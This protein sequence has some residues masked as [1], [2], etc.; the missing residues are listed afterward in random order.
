MGSSHFL[1]DGQHPA[2][3]ETRQPKRNWRKSL[4]FCRPTLIIMDTEQKKNPSGEMSI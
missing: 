2:G 4:R 1:F 3:D